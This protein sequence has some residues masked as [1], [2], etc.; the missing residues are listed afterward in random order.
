M[1]HGETRYGWRPAGVSRW[2][3][4]FSG[5]TPTWFSAGVAVVLLVTTGV[6]Y[7]A[8]AAR[9]QGDVAPVNLPVP[10]KAIPTQI[11]DWAGVDQEIPSTQDIYMKRNFADDY[12]SRRYVNASQG[13]WADVYVVYCSS[14]PGGILGHQPLKC[15]PGNGWIHD[16]TEPSQFITQSGHPIDCLV[17]RFHKPAP[18]YQQVVVL[19]FYVLNGQITLSE[20]DFSGFWGRAPNISG[21]PA[22][23]VAQVQVS[24][25]LE[26][27]ART[28]AAQMTDLILALL[29]DQNGEG[30]TNDHIPG[31]FTQAGRAAES[32]R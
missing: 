10:L 4:M 23:Y 11:G 31:D 12:V 28:A 18:S 5:G 8:L 24:S 17:H 1:Y 27:S 21:D 30:S 14:R 26:H 13:L 6:A 32:R 19:N 3:T 15:Y 25:T 2:R 22:R 20:R 7:R 29:P 9:F 16:D